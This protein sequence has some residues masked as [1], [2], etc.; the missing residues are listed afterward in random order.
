MANNLK[1]LPLL[2]PLLTGLPACSYMVSSATE[3]LAENVATAI[4]NENDPATVREGAPAY[5]IL[6][7]GLIAREPDKQNLLLLA[8]EMN[9]AYAAVFVDDAVRAKRM[10]DKAWEY[11]RRALCTVRPDDC[12]A[13]RQPYAD[14]VDFLLD[15]DHSDVPVLYEFAVS[16]LNWIQAHS[17]D[18]EAKADLPKVEATFKRVVEL[19]ADYRQ[20]EPQLYLGVLSIL[21]PPALGGKPEQAETYFE[22]ALKLSDGRNLMYKVV[23][24]ERYA[25]LLFDRPLHDRLLEEVIAADPEQPGLTLTNIIAKQKARQLLDN[26]GDYF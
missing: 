12:Q 18:W 20:G 11:A 17:D 14:Y 5:L 19:D 8:A 13:F 22:Q 16:W 15:I 24:A 25:R 2:L 23:Y 3:N 6:M 26:A 1:T 9:N 7:D 10:T 4:L 21:R